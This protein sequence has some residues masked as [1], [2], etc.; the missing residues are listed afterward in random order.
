[1]VHFSI[2][3]WYTFGLPYTP[4][5]PLCTKQ[6]NLAPSPVVPSVDVAVMF[7][8]STASYQAEQS[9]PEPRCPVC[10]SRSHVWL[11]HRFVPS[12]AIS[13]QD[14]PASRQFKLFL[15]HEAD[16][17]DLLCAACVA[18]TSRILE[19]NRS[20]FGAKIIEKAVETARFIAVL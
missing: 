1:M 10:F 11:Q 12:R 15:Q 2:T 9:R 3:K 14:C 7:G 16:S 6:H 17:A 19:T 20:S 4:K 5:T 13:P 8:C 18:N